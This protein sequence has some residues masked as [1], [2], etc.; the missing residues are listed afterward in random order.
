MT[1]HSTTVLAAGAVAVVM[2]V[3]CGVRSVK[4]RD[5]M[6]PMLKD[7]DRRI[8]DTSAWSSS[9]PKR[10]DLIAIHLKYEHICSVIGLPGETVTISNGKVS[11]NDAVLSEPYLA[12]GT[13]TTAP[14]D[15]SFVPG[16]Q[17]F[18]LEDNRAHPADSR[19]QGLVPITAIKGT[20]T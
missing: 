4:V 16:S 9:T 8:V 12:H 19:T 14:Q 15:T 3:A 11:I 17:Y 7:G 5:S 6:A 10:G 2:V 1:H 20:L 13:Q 18:V